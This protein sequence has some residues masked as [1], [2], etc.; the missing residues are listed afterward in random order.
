[1]PQGVEHSYAVGIDNGFPKFVV[2][3]M[4]MWTEGD[5]DV[6]MS[7]VRECLQKYLNFKVCSFNRDFYSPTNW[8]ALDEVFEL[9][10]LSKKGKCSRANIV[11][12]SNE[13]FISARR[14]HLGWS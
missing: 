13:E 14:I 10:A 2:H 5:T 7:M 3:H 8:V 11:Q 12:K 6:A 9:I 1:M 4:I